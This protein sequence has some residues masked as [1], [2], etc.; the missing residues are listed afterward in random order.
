MP[1]REELTV[2]MSFGAVIESWVSEI[3]LVSTMTHPGFSLSLK[4]AS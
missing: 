2:E 1:S 3:K 4:T